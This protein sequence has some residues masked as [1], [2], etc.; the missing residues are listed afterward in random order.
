M[1]TLRA[2][3][4]LP[5]TRAAAIRQSASCRRGSIAFLICFRTRSGADATRQTAADARDRALF[6]AIPLR[7][8]THSVYDGTTVSAADLAQLDA[9]ARVEGGD[10]VLIAEPAKC[11][12]VL[13]QVIAGNSAQMDDPAFVAELLAWFRLGRSFQ[14]FALQATALGLRH[15]H[16]N[17]PVEVPAIRSAFAR[18]PGVGERRPDPM[19]RFGRAPTLPMSMRRPVGA[20]LA[21]AAA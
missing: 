21:E 11:E 17:Q 16:I 10:A 13:A 15:A 4:G 7:Q 6:A 1:P 18:W 12:D 14:R 9:A 2:V 8:S 5:R 3:L 20:V 19:I